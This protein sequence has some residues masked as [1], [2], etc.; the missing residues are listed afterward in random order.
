MYTVLALLLTAI[1]V[2]GCGSSRSN[3]DIAGYD[4]LHVMP[5]NE[6]IQ[7]SDAC[8][9]S[10]MRPVVQTISQNYN[11]QSIEVPVSVICY[12]TYGR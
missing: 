8:K 12:P 10:G 1:L 6:V 9:S 2:S 3:P 11:G 7:R 5:Q 4:G